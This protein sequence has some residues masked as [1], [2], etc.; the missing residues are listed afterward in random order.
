M[1]DSTETLRKERLA[2]LNCVP[3]SRE[4]LESKYGSVWTTDELTKEFSVVGFMAPFCVVVR[5]ADGVRGSVEFQ[6]NPRYF[7]SFQPE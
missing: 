4:A 1:S 2:E 3:G 6:H 5:R 7:F